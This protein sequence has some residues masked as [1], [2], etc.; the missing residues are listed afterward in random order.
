VVC[1]FSNVRILLVDDDA[2]WRTFAIR[3]L[4]D[5]GLS[6]IDVAY[7]GVQGV[8]KAR[9]LQPDVILMDVGLP[10]MN[11]IEAAAKMREAAPAAKVVFVSGVTD[12]HMIRAAL[13]AGGVAYV[14][15]SL[16]ARELIP[17]IKHALQRTST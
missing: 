5:A 9:T 1:D 8:F 7:D 14:L 3:I 11:G 17:A 2:L 16:A 10:H 15:K 4:S 12:P 6:A 13:D